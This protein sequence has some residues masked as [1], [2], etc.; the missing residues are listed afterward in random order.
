[1]A[2]TRHTSQRITLVMLVL[3][4]ITAI[5]LDYHGEA[6]RAIGHVRNGVRDVLSPVQRV[7]A[8]ALHPL[9]DVFAGAVHY[10]QLQAENAQL[11]REL[12][13]V[14]G[15]LAS[16]AQ[17]MRASEQLVALAHLPFV[18][19]NIPTVAAS[20]ISLATSNFQQ[21]IE[22]DRGTSSGIGPG[23]PVVASG[24][25]VGTVTS[26]SAS[27]ATVELITDA[28]SSIS[29]RDVATNAIFVATGGGS[30]RPVALSSGGGSIHAAA[31]GDRLVTSGVDL[32][33]YPAG[34][35]FG[36]VRSVRVQAGG[37]TESVTV[38]PL[39]NLAN[40]QYV[41]V[42]EWLQPA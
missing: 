33:A 37:A 38:T 41:S 17:A 7:A 28:S 18:G 1:M 34:I 19:A 36:V 30:G 40:L 29:V 24:G 32:G 13:L 16:G 26:A 42:L 35:P 12:G 20:V 27:T 4:S 21:T 15:E 14:N 39:V 9:G 2:A 8:A 10:G 6:S 3:A 22:L 11:R 5:T 23:M 25:L 31:L